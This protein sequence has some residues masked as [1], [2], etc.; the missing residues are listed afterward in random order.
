[1]NSAPELRWG[2]LLVPSR[3]GL[4]FKPSAPQVTLLQSEAT[5]LWV[6]VT[7]LSPMDVILSETDDSD[8]SKVWVIIFRYHILILHMWYHSSLQGPSDF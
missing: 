2:T 7:V 3:R 4:L 6:F 5:V 1:M 8:D